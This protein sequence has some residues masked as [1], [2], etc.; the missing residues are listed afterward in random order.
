[1]RINEEELNFAE[2]I[3]KKSI[4][5]FL[6]KLNSEGISMGLQKVMIKGFRM[7]PQSRRQG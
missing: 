2:T 4:V 1:M 6:V 7:K 5:S 3:G